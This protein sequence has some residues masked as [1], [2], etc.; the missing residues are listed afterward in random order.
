MMD[1][2]LKPWGRMRT[3]LRNPA[4]EVVE[5]EIEAGGYCSLHYHNDKANAFLVISGCLKLKLYRDGELHATHLLTRESMPFEV[6]A[7][8]PHQFEATEETR[9]FE[10]YRP[11][12]D[13]PIRGDDIV[14]LSEGGMRR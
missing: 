1:W 6:P 14:R 12:A 2:T 7:G 11:V 9:L 4:V 5:A 13:F 8:V 10:V 3:I